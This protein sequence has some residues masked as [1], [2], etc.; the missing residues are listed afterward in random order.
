MKALVLALAL[1]AIAVAVPAPAAATS[2]TPTLDL[3]QVCW[4]VGTSPA[5]Y[6]CAHY[7]LGGDYGGKC[8][9]LVP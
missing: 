5:P 8:A 7:K 2:C 6:A 4:G 3:L 9:P 1:L